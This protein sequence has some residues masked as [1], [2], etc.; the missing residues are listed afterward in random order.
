MYLALP[1]QPPMMIGFPGLQSAGTLQFCSP[2]EAS[3]LSELHQQVG[4]GHLAPS[5]RRPM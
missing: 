3:R 4:T 1:E 2:P 5:E